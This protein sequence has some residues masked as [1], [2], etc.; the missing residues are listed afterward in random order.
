MD[1]A[2]IMSANFPLEWTMYL[3]ELSS[4]QLINFVLTILFIIIEFRND[5]GET[6]RSSSA[7]GDA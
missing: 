7:L 5:N 6:N 2:T 4:T 1:R 3:S